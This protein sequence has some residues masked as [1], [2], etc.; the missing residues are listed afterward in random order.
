ME[1]FPDK[2]K[3][4]DLAL[5][6]NHNHRF[7]DTYGVAHSTQGDYVVTPITQPL[8]I[9][10]EF[11][12]LPKDFSKLNLKHLQKVYMDENPLHFWEEIRGMFS[13]VHGETLRFILSAKIPLKTILRY[14]L[15]TR[16]YD[17]IFNYIGY[18]KA[19]ALWCDK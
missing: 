18:E 9:H 19:L 14:E 2:Q 10:S 5:W 6:Q 4:I 7:N 12:K 15:A 17:E 11:V 13:G 16:G 3:A 8:S 1:R